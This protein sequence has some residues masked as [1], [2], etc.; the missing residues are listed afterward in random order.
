MQK[1]AEA[2][3]RS[4]GWDLRGRQMSDDMGALIASARQQLGAPGASEEQVVTELG[5][6]ASVFWNYWLE[7]SRLRHEMG[8]WN[9]Y[10]ARNRRDPNTP[11]SELVLN[12]QRSLT[13]LQ[14]SGL[15]TAEWSERVTRLR[16]AMYQERL[17]GRAM[18]LTNAD[19]HPRLS[20]CP[21]P[22]T[23]TSG[24][25]QAKMV[26]PKHGPDEFY[27]KESQ[28]LDEQGRVILSVRVDSTGCGANVAI[29]MSSGSEPLDDAAL[30]YFETMEFLP[31]QAQGI[32]V[33]ALKS[34]AVS[35]QIRSSESASR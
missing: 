32:A 33:G 15:P 30:R 34:L 31:A 14:K 8:L 20:P 23:A 22:A 35:F 27:P 13:E 10:L 7:S 17:S 12:A 18:V 3:D 21:A 2:A 19:Y 9:S 28:Q 25:D 24:S 16:D 6:R 26:P 11:H 4:L 5:Q 29:A 1:M